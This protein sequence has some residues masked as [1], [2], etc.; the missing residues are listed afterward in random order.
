MRL[1]H[2]QNRITTDDTQHLC[3]RAAVVHH[4]NLMNVV[5]HHSFK[6]RQQQLTS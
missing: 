4:R 1:D 5:R 3:K 2:S 6:Q